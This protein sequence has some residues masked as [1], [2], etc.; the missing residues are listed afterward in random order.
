MESVPFPTVVFDCLTK[1]IQEINIILLIPLREETI[2]DGSLDWVHIQRSPVTLA[3]KGGDPDINRDFAHD[4]KDDK[5]Q[6]T[7][8]LLPGSIGWGQAS[9]LLNSGLLTFIDLTGNLLR[10]RRL[11]LKTALNI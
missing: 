8:I 9:A 10:W 6:E 5:E 2:K 1:S 3:K 4:Y 7:A 11:C